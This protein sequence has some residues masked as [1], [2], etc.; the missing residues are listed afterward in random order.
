MRVYYVQ[1]QCC[2]LHLPL[3][4]HVKK[5]VGWEELSGMDVGREGERALSISEEEEVVMFL[6]FPFITFDHHAN[7]FG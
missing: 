2:H 6:S 5:G 4:M 3:G 1:H 7:P